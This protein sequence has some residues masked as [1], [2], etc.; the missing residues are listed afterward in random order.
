[1]I[2]VDKTQVLYQEGMT[3]SNLIDQLKITSVHTQ[4]R[5]IRDGMKDITVLFDKFDTYTLPDDCEVVF[6]MIAGG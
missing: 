5:I 6:I 3:I 1:M 4:V 2:K